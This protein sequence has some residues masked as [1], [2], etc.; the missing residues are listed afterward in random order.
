MSL[1]ARGATDRP[2]SVRERR[3]GKNKGRMDVFDSD[4]PDDPIITSTLRHR[5]DPD[6]S[7]VHVSL[8]IRD[9]VIGEKCIMVTRSRIYIRQI[10]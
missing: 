6:I 9:V 4:D 7:D 8:M 5:D 1:T 10:G 3:G 2:S